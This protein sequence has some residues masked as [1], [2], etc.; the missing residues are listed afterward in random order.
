[1]KKERRHREPE[2]KDIITEAAPLEQMP[3][4]ERSHRQALQSTVFSS[5]AVGV[6]RDQIVDFLRRWSGKNRSAT[7]EQFK[8]PGGHAQNNRKIHGWRWA[9]DR[10]VADT[11]M[12]TEW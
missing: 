6:L 10:K 4:L 9:S 12:F 7:E 5:L 1:M 2:K 11:R 8:N 3:V